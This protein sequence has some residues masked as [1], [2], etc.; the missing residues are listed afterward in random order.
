[1]FT[2]LDDSLSIFMSIVQT[3]SNSINQLGN[4]RKKCTNPK[5]KKRTLKKNW[6]LNWRKYFLLEKT[7]YNYQKNKLFIQYLES[8]LLLML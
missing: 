8:N 7:I 2:T 4:R 5:K 3:Y 6:I 1:M